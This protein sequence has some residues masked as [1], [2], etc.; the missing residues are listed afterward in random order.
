MSAWDFTARVEVRLRDCE[1]MGHV[2]NAVYNTYLE[3]ARFK[4][5]RA[6]FGDLVPGG[7]SFIVA[8]ME[9]DYRAPAGPG[10]ELEVRLRVDG[11]GRSSFVIAAQIVRPSDG[12]VIR[13]AGCDGDVRL[14]APGVDP[15]ARRRA[16]RI[17]AQAGREFPRPPEEPAMDDKVLIFGK[18]GCPYT[19]AARDDYA[20]RGKAVTYINVKK[21][22]A[23]LKRMLEHSSGRRCVPVIVEGDHVTVGFGGT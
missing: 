16:Q 1:P 8:R 13:L 17:E 4:Y 20:K 9:M 21:D 22:P 14:R 7:T 10:D 2:N 5:W 19:Q 6:V 23:Y 12:R 11:I 15:A 3:V 18:D